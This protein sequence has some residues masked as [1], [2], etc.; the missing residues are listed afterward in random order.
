MDTVPRHQKYMHQR[1]PMQDYAHTECGQ[2]PQQV[3]RPGETCTSPC[4]TTGYVSTLDH[5]VVIRQHSGRKPL[6]TRPCAATALRNGS[7]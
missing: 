2:Q 7:P 4:A 3:S 1:E 6:R 5:R